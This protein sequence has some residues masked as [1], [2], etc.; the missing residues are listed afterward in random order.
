M[1]PVQRDDAGHYT[2]IAKRKGQELIR[3]KMELIVEE[4]ASGDDPPQFIRRL[5][6]LSVKVGTRTRLLAEIKSSTELKV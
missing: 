2:L 6:D 3:R 5:M 1:E 4:R